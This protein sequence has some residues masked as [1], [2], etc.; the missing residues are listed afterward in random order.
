MG[1][2]SV[3]GQ[4]AKAM[5]M[6][7]GLNDKIGNLSYYD[8]TAEASFSK[9]YSEQTA[10][11]I[12]Q[13]ISKIIESSYVRALDILKQNQA[14]LKA[15]AQ[16]LLEKEVIFREDVERILGSRPFPSETEIKVEEV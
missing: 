6:I 13:E 4:T 2:L 7:Y 8:P 14:G 10:Q 3:F 11:I 5:V 16:V 1:S 15:L 9:P 12:D